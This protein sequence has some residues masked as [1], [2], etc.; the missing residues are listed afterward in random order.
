MQFNICEIDGTAPQFLGNQKPCIA[1]FPK[2]LILQHSINRKQNAQELLDRRLQTVK[3]EQSPA[4][5]PKIKEKVVFKCREVT[6]NEM[7]TL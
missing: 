1:K 2:L 3:V 7:F 4:T 6:C 5:A